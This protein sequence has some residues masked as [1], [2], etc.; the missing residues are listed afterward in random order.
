M[1]SE[2]HAESS[3]EHGLA[4]P[5]QY[6]PGVGPKRARQFEK[7]GIYTVGDLFWHLP[8]AYEDF[9]STTRIESLTAGTTATIQ[10]EITHCDSRFVRGRIRNILTAIIKDQTGVVSAVWFNQAY[11]KDKLQPG[12]RV[13]LHGK[14]ENKRGRL[15][16]SS[17]KVVWLDRDS[18]NRAGLNAVYPLME[19]IRQGGM[20]TV[21]QKAFERFQNGITEMLPPVILDQYGFPDR[22]ECFRILHFPNPHEGAPT[23]DPNAQQ[24]LFDHGPEDIEAPDTLPEGQQESP[25]EQ[26][27]QRLVY[28]ELLIHQ[29][30][31]SHNRQQIRSL[32]GISHVA[33]VPSPWNDHPTS[34][35]SQ[36]G[37]PAL[38][39]QS[40]PFQLTD[41]QRLVCREIEQ[42]MCSSFPMNRLLQGD[43]GSGKTVVSVYGMVL[44]AAG[45]Y[46]SVL[47]APTELLAN[48]HAA[49]MRIWLQG[50]PDIQVVVLTGS[51]KGAGRRELMAAIKT[52]GA[53]MIVGT[54]ALFQE[55]VSFNRLGLVII[56]EQ[57]KFGVS[58]RD[59]LMQ[60]GTCPDLLV[61]TATPI[62]RTLALTRFGD[63][64]VSA[65]RTLPPGRPPLVTRWT[66]WDKEDKVWEF[67]DEKVGEGQQAY[68]V[69][70]LIETSEQIPQ[71]PSVE[72]IHSRIQK[73]LPNRTIALLHGRHSPE[74]KEDL[75]RRMRSGEIDLVVSTTVVEV[76]VDLPNA[77]IMVILGA[78]RFGLAQLH[79]LRGRVGRGTI[80]SYCIL[81]TEH[82]LSPYAEQRM[83]AMEATRDGFELAEKDLRL[84]GPGEVFGARQSGHYPFRLADPFRDREWL[85]RANRDARE[86]MVQDA[87]MKQEQNQPLQSELNRMYSSLQF[88]R[89]S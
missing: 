51:A 55:A 67:V 33:P 74:E 3:P 85:H 52:G 22:K 66:Q 32:Q 30:L 54:H 58:Q 20:R 31:L 10:G 70:P 77:T 13:R 14:I 61:A 17:P 59:R 8:R 71:L 2:S 69:C 12:E 34:S 65:I 57:H 25:W 50:I 11:L 60:K 82:E 36:A 26:A 86:L 78:N 89:P 9:G 47:M 27:R 16:M 42:D 87:E 56:D 38:F 84:R 62:P 19:G 39:L 28:E 64:D 5:I 37:W 29:L 24:H 43:V 35:S 83:R 48:Q 68:V 63:M 4:T 1:K 15:Q 18:S 76:G 41:D 49:T 6:C 88:Q 73:R 53:T 23:G 45:G 75:M 80:K 46:Q 79:Q 7:L 40:L 72:E 21:M 44:A 81:V